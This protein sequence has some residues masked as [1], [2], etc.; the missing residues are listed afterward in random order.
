[1]LHGRGG[2][3][4][5]PETPIGLSLTSLAPGEAGKTI[6][7]F[8]P[9]AV[10]GGPVDGTTFMALYTMQWDAHAAY[11]FRNAPEEAHLVIDAAS[12][13]LLRTQPLAAHADV[14]RWDQA[15]GRYV[16][17]AD[18]GIRELAD[19]TYPLKAGEVMHVLPQWHANV[20]AAGYHYFLATTNNRRNEHAPAGHSGPAHCLGRVRIE[21]GKVEYLELP[22]GVERKPGA[23]DAF[24]YGRSLRTRTEDAKGR[25]VAAE[26]RSR[27]D[28]WEIDAFFPTPVVLGGKVY[29]SV[30][31]GLTYV[32]DARAAVLDEHALLAVNDLGPLGETW[33]MSSPSYSDGMLY[34]RSLKELVAIGPEDASGR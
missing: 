32:I 10:P 29:I 7:R 1:V 8:A 6:W 22:V 18:V 13:R 16:L 3:H 20:V 12:G 5:V 33:S 19:P 17:Q 30:A 4:G 34:H 14:R 9:E 24:I 26:D 11:W 31:L 15:Q 25:D 21:T 28:G 23:P 2:P 27:T